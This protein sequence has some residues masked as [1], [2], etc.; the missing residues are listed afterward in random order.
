MAKHNSGYFDERTLQFLEE[1]LRNNTRDWFNEN[2]PR[3]ESDVLDKSL[4]FIQAMQAPLEKISPYFQAVPKR[5]GG[6][7]MRVYRDTRFGKD[8]TPYKTNIGIQFRHE[9]ARDVHAPGFYLHIDPQRV[10]VGAG[11]WRPAAPALAKIRARIDAL[12]GEWEK[13]RDQPTFKKQFE[14]SGESLV[15]PPRGY[16]G[17]HPLLTDLR[18]KDFI[19]L[20]ELSHEDI[21]EPGFLRQVAALFKTAAPF[22]T[23]LCKSMDLR[24]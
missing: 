20:S 11:M 4:A 15:R 1:L 24:Y 6:S 16:S 3:Y 7:L 12:P 13:A 2:K 23:F 22:M 5:M 17:D 8:K 9:L 18:R 21:L 10:F 14:L 19:A